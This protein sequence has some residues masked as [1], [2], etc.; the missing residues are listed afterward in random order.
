MFNLM[1]TSLF[2][3]LIFIFLIGLV[4][5]TAFLF[6]LR[7]EQVIFI[8]YIYATGNFKISWIVM[9]SMLTGILITLLS[10]FPAYL[11]NL[12][13]ILRLKRRKGKSLIDT[14]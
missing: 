4:F 1:E 9:G 12:L 13:T 3:H 10:L 14:D 7:N 8:D 2:S 6:H 11:K 5:L